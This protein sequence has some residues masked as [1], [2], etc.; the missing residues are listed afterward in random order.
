MPNARGAPKWTKR[1]PSLSLW[2]TSW[3]LDST[4]LRS[5]ARALAEPSLLVPSNTQAIPHDLACPGLI[6]AYLPGTRRSRYGQYARSYQIPY[7]NPSFHTVSNTSLYT[8]IPILPIYRCR[9]A[10][11]QRGAYFCS[12]T[13]LCDLIIR[14][15]NNNNHNTT[16]DQAL[17]SK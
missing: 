14:D 5:L 16:T 10:G 11:R 12:L 4:Q 13:A 3:S 6:S 9:A 15:K 17:L 8:L 1:R 2:V 7:Q